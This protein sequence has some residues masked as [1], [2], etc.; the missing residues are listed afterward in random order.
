[1]TSKQSHKL[2]KTSTL[3]VEVLTLAV[4]R[5]SHRLHRF[6]HEQNQVAQMHRLPIQQSRSP[7]RSLLTL[8]E[9]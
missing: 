3:L 7:H 5:V 4:V 6:S 9:V 2:F 1:M 8:V